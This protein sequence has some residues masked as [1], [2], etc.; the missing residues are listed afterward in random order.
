LGTLTEALTVTYT[1]SGTA[2]AGVDYQALPGTVTFQAGEDTATVDLSIIDDDI[3]EGTENV[4]LTI[5]DNPKYTLNYGNSETISIFDN[6]FQKSQLIQPAASN[7][8]SLEGGAGQ[9][10]L[11]FTKLSN[12]G[13][14]KNELAAFVVDDE[15][16][17][18]DGILPGDEKYLAAAIARSQV[19]FSSLGDNEIDRQFDLDS[20]RYLNFNSGDRIQ[21]LLVVDDTIDSIQ[22]NLDTGNSGANVIFSLPTA[23]L[24]NSVGSQFTTLS[25]NGGYQIAWSDTLDGGNRKFNNFIIQVQTSDSYTPTIGNGLQGGLLGEVIDLRDFSE[26]TLKLDISTTSDARY[27]NYIGFY[28]VEDALGT[29]E[30][31]LKPDGIGYAESAIKSAILQSYKNEFKSD[32]TVSGGKILAPVVIA[33]GTFKDFMD[34]NPEN[35]ANSSVH[36]YFNY[37][38]ANPDKVDHFRLLGDNKFGVEDMFGGGDRDYNDIVIQ[39]AVRN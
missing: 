10:L 27:N 8:I 30:N 25:D 3:Y 22:S 6:E 28:E 7:G 26:Q 35:Q 33:N 37:L 18:I 4:T 1:L 11:K 15:L 12:T 32:L 17:A 2:A 39:L 20:H 24:N 29:L 13:N 19:I 23:N 36:A 14:N 21:F 9:S 31:G 5:D 16:S 38:G 34:L